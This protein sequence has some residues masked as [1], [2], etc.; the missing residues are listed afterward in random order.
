ME[1]EILISSSYIPHWKLF[2]TNEE[3]SIALLHLS[4]RLTRDY[5]NL[6]TVL[7]G[8]LMGAAYFTVDLSRKLGINHTVI[9]IIMHP[10]ILSKSLVSLILN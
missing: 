3:I 4:E 10:Q 9:I 8:I 7:V 6:N 5:P 2:I 1:S